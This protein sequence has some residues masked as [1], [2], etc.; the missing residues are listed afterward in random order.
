MANGKNP[1]LEMLNRQSVPASVPQSTAAP[2]GASP[3][4]MGLTG[5]VAADAADAATNTCHACHNFFRFTRWATKPN[6]WRTSNG[7]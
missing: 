4:S 6:W 2:S 1:I 3:L 7:E 5:A